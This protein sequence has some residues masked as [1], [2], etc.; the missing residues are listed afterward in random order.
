MA[1]RV[2]GKVALVI[3]GGQTPGETIGNGRATALTLA[4]EG[5]LVAVADRRLESAQDTASMIQESGGVAEA[6]QGDV[7]DEASIRYS[8]E[9][10]LLAA[11]FDPERVYVSEIVP[12]KIRLNLAYAAHATVWTDILVILATMRQLLWSSVLERRT[13]VPEQDDSLVARPTAR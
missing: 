13:V 12:D 4:R 5:A 11:A 9:S 2:E 8:A 1:G 6:F 7:T 3:G 10:A